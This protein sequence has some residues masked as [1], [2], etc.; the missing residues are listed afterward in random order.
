MSGLMG[1]AMVAVCPMCTCL[2]VST[3]SHP[4]LLEHKC[5]DFPVS[6]NLQPGVVTLSRKWRSQLWEES[7]QKHVNVSLSL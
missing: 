2:S 5:G 1:Q 6:A 7:P 4:H 3:P